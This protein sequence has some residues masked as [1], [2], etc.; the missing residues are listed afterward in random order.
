MRRH[1]TLIELLVVIGIICVLA[2]MLMP[3]LGKAREKAAQTD[4]LNNQKQLGLAFIMYT[5]DFKETYP[6]VYGGTTGINLEGGWIFYDG[7]PVPS[8]GQFIPSRGALFPYVN[9]E[10]PFLCRSDNSGTKN[11]YSVNCYLSAAKSS[12]VKAPTETPLLLEEGTGQKKT[13]NDGY[14]AAADMVNN[15]HAKGAVFSFCDGHSSFEKW[16]ATE[17]WDRNNYNKE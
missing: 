9:T 15:R 6:S 2:G 13:S 11:S 10:K 7:Y 17:I 14:F 8:A 5:N 3:A 16:T 12:Q 4:C 1:F